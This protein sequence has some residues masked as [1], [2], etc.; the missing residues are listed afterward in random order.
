MSPGTETTIDCNFPDED[1]G[2]QTYVLNLL[3]L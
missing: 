2:L 1:T 3:K